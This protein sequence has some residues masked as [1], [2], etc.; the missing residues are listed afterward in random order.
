[1]AGCKADLRAGRGLPAEKGEKF[2]E[3]IGLELVPYIQKKYRT[4]PFRIIAGHD[5]TAGFLN[6]FLYKDQPLF[7]GYIS[8]SPE[9]AP[10]M[11]EQIPER[12][13][14]INQQIFYLL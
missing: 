12:L 7:S 11:E 2:F 10:G 14:L 9:L 13:N 4:S 3:F 6:L 5:I 1:M 8:L